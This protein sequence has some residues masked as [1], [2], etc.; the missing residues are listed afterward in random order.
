MGLF[1][2]L[3]KRRRMGILPEDIVVFIIGP[4]GSGK[5][6]FLSTLLQNPNVHTLVKVSREH[7][8]SEVHAVRCRFEGIPNDILLVDTPSFYVD[9]GPDAEATLKKWMDSNDTKE[10]WAIG[11]LYMHNIAS[12][13]YDDNLRLLKH[14][15]AF[16]RTCRRDL[17]HSTV[18]VVPSV[19][20]E[21]RLSSGRIE[22]SMSRLQREAAEGGTLM[23]ATLFD[24]K[25]EIAWGIMQ[26]LFNNMEPCTRV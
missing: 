17:S 8:S 7:K 22:A 21:V 24:G 26:G 12:N 14:I 9:H 16:R 2:F 20:S 3:R 19:A 5:S 1:D 23:Y 10:S 6:W 18:Y 13:L 15:G 25:P 4:S 11:I